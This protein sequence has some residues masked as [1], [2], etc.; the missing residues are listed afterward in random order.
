MKLPTIIREHWKLIIYWAIGS[1]VAI[2]ALA[3]LVFYFAG[4]V[5]APTSERSDQVVAFMNE[6]GDRLDDVSLASSTEEIAA[7]MDEQYGPYL[8]DDLLASWKNDPSIALGKTKAGVIPDGIRIKSVRNVGTLSY[9][10]K[11]FI[12]E[13]VPTV[14]PG[15]GAVH[16]VGEKPYTFG[17]VWRGGGWEIVEYSEGHA[18]PIE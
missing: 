2:I 9:T 5:L 3:S 1:I 16:A 6:F 18:A 10:V 15:L 11:A 12:K 4:L 14:V 7:S 13:R 17:V 8:S